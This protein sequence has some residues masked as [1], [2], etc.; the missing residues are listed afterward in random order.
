VEHAVAAV[1]DPALTPVAGLVLISPAIGVTPLAALAVWQAR[2][3]SLLG[4]PKLAWNTIL[5]ELDPFKYSSFAVNAGDQVRQLTAAVSA[6]LDRLEAQGRLGELPPVLAFQSLADATVSSRAVVDRLFLR[7]QGAGH[8][9]VDFDLNRR[10]A[11]EALLRSDPKPS[12]AAD[13][14]ERVLPFTL[15]FVTN[16][17][18]TS[19]DVVLR[20][21]PAGSATSRERALGLSWPPGVFSL[22][23]VAL[24]F[25]SDDPLYGAPGAPES[26]GIALGRAELRGER[27]LLALSPSE[28][29]RL[30]WNPFY[31]FLE[32]RVVEALGLAGG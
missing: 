7:L 11:A 28:L 22:T 9:L 27:G 23:H 17:S 1:E 15:A 18:E 12:V 20:T 19:P 14:G 32:A 8:E 29:V 10:A 3:G 13:L 24:P 2:L 30:R 6:G 25:P 26:P 31:D 21:K 5:P 4:L 16:E